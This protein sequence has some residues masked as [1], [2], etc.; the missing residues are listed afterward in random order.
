MKTVNLYIECGL[1]LNPKK[2]GAALLRALSSDAM[3]IVDLLIENKA[4]LNVTSYS[5]GSA[6]I[7][8]VKKKKLDLLQRLLECGAKVNTASPWGGTAANEAVA[9]GIFFLIIIFDVRGNWRRELFLIP[10]AARPNCPSTGERS[11]LR[12]KRS[13]I[14]TAKMNKNFLATTTTTK[15]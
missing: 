11:E 5:E 2:S 6:L 1:E 8:C 7:C 15:K 13:G 3:E 4:D 14:R 9:Q 10:S 12:Y